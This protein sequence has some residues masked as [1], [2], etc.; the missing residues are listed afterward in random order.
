MKNVMDRSISYIHP[1]FVN[2]NG[3]MH[4]RRRYSNRARLEVR[5]Y[6]DTTEQ[7]KHTARSLVEAKIINLWWE[8]AG[9]EF[10]QIP[11]EI[12]GRVT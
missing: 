6:G 8:D 2:K 1:F 9:V 12:A 5:F 4:H 10:F 3:E 7:E 11:E